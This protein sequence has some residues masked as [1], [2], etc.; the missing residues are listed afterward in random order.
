MKY[1]VKGM[2]CGE[3]SGLK[4]RTKRSPID[5]FFSGS[6]KVTQVIVSPKT[7]KTRSFIFSGNLVFH[8][9]VA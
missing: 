2:C 4:K 8:L 3:V 7:V 6:F 9:V 5:F 1:L